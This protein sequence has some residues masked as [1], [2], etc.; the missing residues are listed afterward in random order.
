VLAK[1]VLGGGE[2]DPV[3]A[4]YGSLAGAR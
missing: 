2:L 4:A 3:L 1:Q